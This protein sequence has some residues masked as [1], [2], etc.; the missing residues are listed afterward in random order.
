MSIHNQNLACVVLTT[1]DGGTIRR[2]RCR[3]VCS[4]K[5][6]IKTDFKESVKQGLQSLH[7]SLEQSAQRAA[8]QRSGNTAKSL[9]ATSGCDSSSS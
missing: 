5:A 7:S 6:S 1:S 2:H 3:R 9:W 8:K 4:L